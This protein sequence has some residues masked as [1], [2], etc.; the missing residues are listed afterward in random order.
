MA[1]NQIFDLL[2]EISKNFNLAK[3]ERLES[4]ALSTNI[5][6]RSLKAANFMMKL[7]TGF[8]KY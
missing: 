5:D 6:I 8:K 7:N 1:N 2:T 3:L 4:M